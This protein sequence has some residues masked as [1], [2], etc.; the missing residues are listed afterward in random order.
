MALRA[1]D[2]VLDQGLFIPENIK[3]GLF[4]HFAFDNLDFH[5]NNVDGKTTHGTTL[6]I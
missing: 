5:E 1:E 3:H 6:I 2:Q 4:T